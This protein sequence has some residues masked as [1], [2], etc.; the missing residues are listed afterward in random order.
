[1]KFVGVRELKIRTSEILRELEKEDVIITRNG[2]PLAVMHRLSSDQ[3]ELS[4]DLVL[5]LARI[6]PLLGAQ[7]PAMARV[8]GDPAGSGYDEVF[9]DE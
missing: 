7:Y 5:E 4:K 9:P 1:M 3:V 2:K 8:W 6:D